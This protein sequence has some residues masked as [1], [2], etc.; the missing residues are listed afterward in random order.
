MSGIKDKRKFSENQ[1]VANFP[2]SIE[3]DAWKVYW[4]SLLCKKEYIGENDCVIECCENLINNSVIEGFWSRNIP[5]TIRS[6]E[7]FIELACGSGSVIRRIYSYACSIEQ[8]ALIVAA[9]ISLK[10]LMFAKH[11]FPM[12]KYVV[13]D[14]NNIPIKNETF[15]YVTSQFGIE[16]GGEK[17]IINSLKLVNMGGIFAGIFHVSGGAI[18]EECLSNQE[19]INNL[20]ES[21]IFEFARTAISRKI[22]YLKGECNRECLRKAHDQFLSS[23]RTIEEAIAGRQAIGANPPADK[24]IYD[25]VSQIINIYN[26]L[27]KFGNLNNILKVISFIEKQFISYM[28]RMSSMV[29]SSL[30][31]STINDIKN[32]MDCQGFEYE[33]DKI[34]LSE[35]DH[36]PFALTLVANRINKYK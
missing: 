31:D 18:E 4:D 2:Y 27:S 29:Q 13:F 3:V 25:A 8:G 7:S 1:R 12:V 9:D 10:A 11:K 34:Y 26:N 20:L 28:A 5:K 23:Y 14:L 30:G 17:S 24:H 6:N 19:S 22:S 16:Y 35:N 33:I 36:K 32:F 15:D 21:N